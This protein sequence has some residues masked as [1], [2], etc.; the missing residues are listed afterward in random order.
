MINTQV[1]LCLGLVCLM[2]IARIG[3]AEVKNKDGDWLPVKYVRIGGTFQNISK[4]KIKKVL[5]SQVTSGFYNADLQQIQQLVKQLPW[6]E[7]VKVKRVWPDAIDIRIDEQMPVVRWGENSLLNNK[8]EKFIPDNIADFE[9]L[10]LLVGPYGNEQ[11]LLTIMGELSTALENQ[12]MILTEFEVNERRAWKIKL[13]NN[14]ELI[15]GRNKPF[16]KF[17]RFLKTIALLG[18]KQIRKI[19]IVDLRYSN[20]FALTWK[21]G[22]EKIDWKQIAEMNKT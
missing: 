3:W 9:Q 13:Q 8:G 5:V 4:E 10:P 7:Q 12:G 20:G 17:Q 16:N 18:E 14:M 21:L 1:Y 22:E 2:I 15:L 6:V 19:A 11:K